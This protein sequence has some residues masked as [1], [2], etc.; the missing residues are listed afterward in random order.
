VGPSALHG[1]RH[2]PHVSPSRRW[3]IIFS[4]G[5]SLAIAS[6]LHLHLHVPQAPAALARYGQGRLRG[7]QLTGMTGR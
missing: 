1:K 4:A 3:L 5:L 2:S 6:H 7:W